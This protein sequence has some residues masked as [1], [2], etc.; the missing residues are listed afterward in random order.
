[1]TSV[2]GKTTADYSRERLAQAVQRVVMANRTPIGDA[3]HFAGRVVERVEQWLTDKTEIT[4]HELRLQ[5][6]GVLADYDAEAA[7]FYKHEKMI[8]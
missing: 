5:T 6:A 4:S 1:M 7:Y 8:I 3:E 2:I